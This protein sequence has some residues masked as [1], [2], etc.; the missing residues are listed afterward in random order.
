[1]KYVMFGNSG[2]QVSRFCLGTMTFGNK[3]DT[4]TADT[5][6]AEAL[7]N[8]V[9]FVDTADSY[10]ESE[11]VLGKI[12]NSSRREKIFLATKVFKQFCRDG[13]AARNSRTNII[14]SLE[15]SLSLMNTDYVDLYQLHHPDDK[16]PIGETLAALD[17]LVKAGKI[18]YI[19]V[20]NHY[21]WQM[22]AM[23]GEAK[24]HNWEPLISIQ[25]SYDILDRQIEQETVPFCNRYNIAIM[26]YGP[27][28]GGIL[29]GKYLH[30]KKPP[31]GTR[32]EQ[33]KLLKQ[34][35]KDEI[36]EHIVEELEEISKKNNIPMN[37]LAILWLM[38]KPHAT[39]IILG[40]SKLEHFNSIYEIADQNLPEEITQ[41]I[42]NVSKPRIHAAFKNQPITIGPVINN[43]R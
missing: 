1:M 20:S 37:Q 29:T 11:Q 18:R 36:V 3:I 35:L 24:L 42:D 14:N 19:G 32:A 15:R 16:T 10:G 34:Y 17:S 5:V 4:K 2:M 39:S 12:L 30:S 21:A 9:N 33:N 13:K 40:G 28:S 41:R 27:L 6:L 26:C 22:A 31:E 43:L 23:L 25:A 38:S 7:D 8:G